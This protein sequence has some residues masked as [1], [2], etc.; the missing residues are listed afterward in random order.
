MFA[1]LAVGD[2]IPADMT[3]PVGWMQIINKQNAGQVAPTLEPPN[4]QAQFA[5]AWSGS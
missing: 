2:T 5:K 1:R 4:Y 3:D